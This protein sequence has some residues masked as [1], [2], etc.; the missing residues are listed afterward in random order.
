MFTQTIVGKGR[1]ANEAL[2]FD[3]VNQI[4]YDEGF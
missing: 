4:G 2:L 3:R 1:N